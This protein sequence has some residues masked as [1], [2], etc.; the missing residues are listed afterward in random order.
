[1]KQS[2]TTQETVFLKKSVGRDENRAM[3]EQNLIH[4]RKKKGFF[5]G[6]LAD[7]SSVSCRMVGHDEIS[8]TIPPFGKIEALAK[9]LGIKP[10][11][12]LESPPTASDDL[13]RDMSDIDPRSIKK[14]K[15]NLCL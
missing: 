12:L 13:R 8:D 2:D 14:L 5:Q 6:D 9:A 7:A 15:D 10:S 3:F 11:R 1:M 4:Y